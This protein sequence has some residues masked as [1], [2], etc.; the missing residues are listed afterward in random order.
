MPDEQDAVVLVDD[1]AL[2]PQGEATR[3]PPVFLHN[4]VNNPAPGQARLHVLSR[5]GSQAAKPSPP[6]AVIVG[7]VRNF[8]HG[9]EAIGNNNRAFVRRA[10]RTSCWLLAAPLEREENARIR[11]LG[12]AA[13]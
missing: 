2:R 3:Q 7:A 1:D 9:N 11:Q 13:A 5:N 10:S 4:P 12:N 8:P 6:S